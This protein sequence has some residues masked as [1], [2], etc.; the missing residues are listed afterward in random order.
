M[1]NVL[2][3]M[4]LP[5]SAF[6]PGGKLEL[7]LGTTNPFRLNSDPQR[8]LVE[9]RYVHEQFVHQA[10]NKTRPD[11]DTKPRSSCKQHCLI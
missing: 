4:V 10:A 7:V 8:L 2:N 5:P 3:L 11:S 9:I 6:I 1:F